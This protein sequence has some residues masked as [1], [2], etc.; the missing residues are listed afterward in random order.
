YLPPIHPI[1]SSHRKGRNNSLECEPADPGSP[2]AIGSADGGHK[3]VHPELGTLADFWHFREVAERL[4]LEVA[5]DVALQASPDHPYVAQHPEWF[6]QRPDGTIQFAE[7]PPKKYQDIYPFDFECEAWESLWEELLS[8]FLFWIEQGV[9]VFRVDNPHTKSLRF[10][11]WCIAELRAREPDVLLLAEAFARPKLM[12]ALAKVGFTQSYTYFTWRNTSWELTEYMRELTQTPVREFFQPNFWPSTPDI[13]PQH[14]QLEGR[15]A[16]VTRLLLAA[17]L[18]SSY[19]IYGPA[20]ELME[21]QARPGSEEYLD[22][23]K[24]ELKAWDVDRPDSLRWQIQHINR[25]R[26]QNPALWNNE[27]LHFHPVDNELLLCFSRRTA[28]GRNTLIVLVNLDSYHAQHGWV[29]LDLDELQLEPTREFQVHDLLADTRYQWRGRRNYV[30]LDPRVAPA[31]VLR[32][33]R[34]VRGEHDFEYFA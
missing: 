18:S 14:L 29:E 20:F 7:N 8:I 21:H 17:L 31:H 10:W 4:G 16:F 24:Y 13:L 27:H 25:I 23:E 12:Y 5:L 30:R 32:V 34:H 15:A 22:N 28:D 1:G 3:S 26:R 9:K 2:W 11:E 6:R 33:R 19:G